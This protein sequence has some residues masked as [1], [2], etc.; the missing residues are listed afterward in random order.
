MNTSV[1]A[2]AIPH[3]RE[4]LLDAIESHRAELAAYLPPGADLNKFVATVRQMVFDVP[5]LLECSVSSVLSAARAA[6]ES[7]LPIDGRFS[8]LIVR[9]S[10]NGPPM[11]IWD[12]SFRG[13]IWL[14]LESGFVV[15][16]QSGVVREH[17]F[18]E[19]E[20]GSEPRIVHRCSLLPKYGDVIAAY[21]SA[22]LRAGGTM[23]EILTRPDI[24]RIRAM[25][26][27][28]DRGPWG[29]WADQMARKSAVRR[30]LKRLPAGTVRNF[31]PAL[32]LKLATPAP[33]IR[34][35]APAIAHADSEASTITPEDGF[36]LE[37]RA[38]EQLAEANSIAALQ[39]AWTAIRADYAQAAVTIPVKVEAKF[40]DR[41]EAFAQSGDDYG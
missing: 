18:F 41:R 1:P 33:K 24:A 25:S 3:A 20:Q 7:G 34:P 29:T 39:A 37:C 23:I 4:S 13:M 14:A 30:L 32:P 16:V 15:D 28:G 17:D 31:E 8:S 36:R 11:A 40:F 9:R 22:K 2:T 27:A 5:G 35:S 6:A 10:K 21:A 26:P 12:P 19:F 38:L